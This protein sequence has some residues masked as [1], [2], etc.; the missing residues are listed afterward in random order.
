MIS[1]AEL[2]SDRQQT[3]YPSYS[4]AS[5][6]TI[7]HIGKFYPPHM[8]GMETHL[9][10]LCAHLRKS[11]NVRVVVASDGH[12]SSE[13]FVDG[14]AVCRLGQR[15]TVASTSF[16]PELGAQIRRTKA[17]IIHVH[18]PNPAAVLAY[19]SSR[20]PKAKLIVTYHSDVI[21]QKVLGAIFEPI[22]HKALRQTSAIIT[23]SPD[24]HRHSPVLLQHAERCRPIPLGI[25]LEPF[26]RCNSDAVRLI[27]AQYGERLV[28]AVGRLVYYK[29]FEYLIR[30]MKDVP[31]KLLI[32]GD[33]PL[34]KQLQTLAAEIGVADRVTLA[35]NVPQNLA[36][37]YH[38]ADVFAF[39]SVARSEAFGIAQV[40]AMACGL[41]VVN[42]QLASGVP[43]VSLHERTGFT[44]PPRDPV[45]LAKAINALLDNEG[46]RRSFG[47]A[48]RLRAFD[49]FSDEQMARRTLE[50]YE[51]VL[52]EERLLRGMAKRRMN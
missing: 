29:G 46:L 17:D 12:S 26:L 7:L 28:L 5:V 45:A 33:G 40:E 2:I 27:R 3:A 9:Q 36:P 30:A 49:E 37:F 16:C 15:L 21:R 24:Y 41:P 51:E 1:N 38:A 32:I 43:F 39:P 23:T 52:G 11:V 8:G 50:L 20:P 13:E 25:A 31:G 35:G 19:L 10:T 47:K 34:R 18:L 42:S 14:V 6:P 48:A 44:V 22:L 4:S